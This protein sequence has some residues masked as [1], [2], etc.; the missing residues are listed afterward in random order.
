MQLNH[1]FG[2]GHS[3]V[4]K[5]CLS[6][7]ADDITVFVNHKDDIKRLFEVLYCYEKASSAK[8][9][10]NESEAFWVGQGHLESIPQ[11]PWDLRWGREGIKL[12]GIF[13]G[14]DNF[15][16]YNWEGTVEKVCTKLS[17]WKYWLPQLSY[18]EELR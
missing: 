9:N 18:G 5:I 15:Q 14:S 16:K 11:L 17:R 10:W 13:F 4:S 7:Y 1:C 2:S 3:F 12:L 8:V 6:A